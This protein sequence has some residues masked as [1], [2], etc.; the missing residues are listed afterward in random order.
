MRPRLERGTSSLRS[1][2][3]PRGLCALIGIGALIGCG[4]AETKAASAPPP[5]MTVTT[6]M[7][8]SGA[9]TRSVTLPTFRVLPYQSATV[10]AKVAGYLKVLKVDKGDAVTEGQLLAEI[11]VPELLA[12]EAQ[13]KAE[14]DV[15]RGNYER[16]AE[17]RR[18][19]PDLV[20]PQTVDELRGR[21]EIA[22]AKLQRTQTLLQ[23]ARITAPF[24]GV[25]TARYVDPGA[26]IP[27]AT[28]GSTPQSAALLTLMDFSRVRVQLYVP[29]AEVPFIK[30]GLAADLTVEE[31][32]GRTFQGTVTRFSNALDESTKT[33]LTEI[34]L[35]NHDHALRP[36]MYASVRLAVE[37]KPNALLVPRDAVVVEKA[38]SFVFT[39]ADGK[40]HKTPV[41]TG[42]NDGVNVE[43]TDGARAGDPVI[44]VGKQTFTD[45]QP[46]VIAKP[47]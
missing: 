34:E 1:G 15:E 46:V 16:M 2:A 40:A 29:E 26:F 3:H 23:F 10:Y 12:D 47:K 42:F 32:P 21:A 7:P 45:G 41:H 44:L 18:K 38:G 37:R 20:V 6:T 25:V 5:P 31:L 28:S 8:K 43:L 14:A 9:I 11:E 22:K 13:F 19:S 27:A 35:P 36:G 33:M 17:A 39:V 24:A 30:N 4:R